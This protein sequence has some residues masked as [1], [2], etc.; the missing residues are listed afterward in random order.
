VS[1]PYEPENDVERRLLDAAADARAMTAFLQA[2]RAG[3]AWIP[4]AGPGDGASRTMQAG[5]TL[6]LPVWQAEDGRRYI[7]VF[8]SEARLAGAVPD[9]TSFV[10]LPIAALLDALEP[11]AWLGVNPRTPLGLLLPAAEVRGAGRV[12]AGTAYAIGE[13]AE[14]PVALLDD[15]RA[16][17]AEEAPAVARAWRALIVLDPDGGG[18]PEPIVGLELEPGAD[19]EPVLTAAVRRLERHGHERVVLVPVDPAAPEG[20]AAWLLEHTRP[21]YERS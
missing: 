13:P 6:A 7:P 9:G 8:T 19:A 3:E 21:F 18:R 4:D 15:L 17:L 2:L 1:A 11:D 20:P 10:R 5:E 14:E 12:A 16:W